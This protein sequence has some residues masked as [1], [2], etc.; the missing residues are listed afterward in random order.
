M[1]GMSRAIWTAGRRRAQ[2]EA[3]ILVEALMSSLII[4]GATGYGAWPSNTLPSAHRCFAAPVDG[5]E[6]DVQMTADGHVVAHHDYRLSRSQTRLD[7]EWIT[8]SGPV[9]KEITLAQL[10]RYD[11]GR[12]RPM[13]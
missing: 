6:I 8:G 7:G 11:I 10:R 5:I 3:T 12:S 4:A 2:A 13:S 1:Q 9:L